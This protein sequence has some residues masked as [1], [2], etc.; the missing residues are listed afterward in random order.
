MQDIGIIGQ[1]EPVYDPLKCI[2][3]Q[4][5]VKNCKRRVT[6]ALTFENFKEEVLKDVKLPKKAKVANTI[7]HT[8]YRYERNTIYD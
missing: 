5:C 3:C 2:G 1:V 8:G 4:A 6:D 7:D